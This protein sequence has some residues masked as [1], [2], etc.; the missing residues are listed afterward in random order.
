VKYLRSTETIYLKE[1]SFHKT[2]VDI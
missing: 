2:D 1:L